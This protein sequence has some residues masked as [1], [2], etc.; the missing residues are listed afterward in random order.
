MNID[1]SVMIAVGEEYK[2]VSGNGKKYNKIF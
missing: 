2:G 1:T